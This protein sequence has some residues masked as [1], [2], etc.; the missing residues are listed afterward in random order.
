[1]SEKDNRR[2]GQTSAA[3]LGTAG[4]ASSDVHHSTPNIK[5]QTG[6]PVYSADGRVVGEV[7][8]DVFTKRVKASV[9][10]LRTPPAIAFDI[11]SLEAASKLGAEFVEVTDV[12]SGY[13]YLSSISDVWANGRRFNRGHGEQIFLPLSRWSVDGRPPK[14]KPKPQAAEVEAE[15]MV[16]V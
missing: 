1:M 16:L 5:N 9:H 8:G 4:G 13:K 3:T 10:F 15:Q 6:T 14:L 12:E 7:K 11:C 2:S